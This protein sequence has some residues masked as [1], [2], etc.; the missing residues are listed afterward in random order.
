[1]NVPISELPDHSRIWI[2]QAPRPL[3]T[4]EREVVAAELENFTADWKAH[5]TPLQAGFSVLHRRFI[6]LAVDETSQ[7]ATGCS[8]D[9]SVGVI[10]RLNDTLGIDFMD[11]MQVAFRSE[12]NLVVSVNLPTFKEMIEA[13]DI[14][15]NTI[16]YNNLVNNLGEFRAQWEIPAGQSWHSRYLSTV[17]G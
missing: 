9:D 16:V 10:R 17:K 4:E 7:A 14:D 15:E 5:G 8:I 6:V 11:R 1:M 13:G 3:T 2:Y 12:N